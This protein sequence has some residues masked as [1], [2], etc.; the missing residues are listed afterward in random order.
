MRPERC[1]FLV[2]GSGIAGL[3]AAL[4]AQAEG[5]HPVIVEKADVWGGSTAISGGVL[6]VP[7]NPLMVAEGAQDDP[8]KARAYLRDLLGE[9]NDR[10]SEARTAAFIANAPEMVRFLGAA[11]MPWRRNREHPDYY[12][13]VAGATVGRSIECAVGDGTQLGARF[14][15]MRGNATALPAFSSSLSGSLIRAKTAREP[16]ATAAQVMA[17]NWFWRLA[18]RKPLGVG[19]ALAGALMKIV[20][21]RGISL[22]LRTQLTELMLDS[23]T[24]IGARLADDQGQFELNA[25]AGVLL[26]TGGFAHNS[27]VRR[28]HQPV[29]GTY[30][31]AI[32]EDQGDALRLAGA[33]GAAADHMDSAWWMPAI[34]MAPRQPTITLG[35]RALP[36]SIIVNA[37][38]RRYMNESQCYMSA[39]QEMI[40]N[41]AAR[42]P[43]WLVADDR[44]MRRYLHRAFRSEKQ[45]EQLVAAGIL[46]RAPTLEQLAQQCELAPAQLAATIARFNG[47]AE[48]GRDEDFGRGDGLYDRYWA[49]PN[50]R[51]NPSLAP[52]TRAPFW[53]TRIFP[54]DLGVNGGLTTDSHARVLHTDGSS[55]SGLYAAG[56]ATSAP[57]GRTYPGAGATIAAAATFGYIA[58]RHAANSTMQQE[59]A[60]RGASSAQ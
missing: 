6:W 12:Q 35:E 23:G 53:A 46:K 29:D 13:H 19:R 28:Q 57:F 16:F 45:R 5:L 59:R 7:C 33:C 8:D 37:S 49:D 58:A 52:L 39:G 32:P 24:V 38:A 27:I 4:T 50:N 20:D 60:R 43:H 1:D 36:G 10:R 30:S 31:I 25:P 15:T 51:P 3:V 11:G 48:K 56:N 54:G 17:Q 2:A 44:F 26:A 21:S 47:F 9:D 34:L 55:I 18:G 22:L 14:P 42:E 41:G 40:A